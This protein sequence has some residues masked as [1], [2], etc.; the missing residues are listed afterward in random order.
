MCQWSEIDNMLN[1]WLKEL[2]TTV[3]RKFLYHEKEC[4]EQI[5]YCKYLNIK[6]LVSCHFS[7]LYYTMNRS[8]HTHFFC[9][10]KKHIELK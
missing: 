4:R 7:I 3:A 6:A 9:I 1:F 5:K 8:Q 10:K 2:L